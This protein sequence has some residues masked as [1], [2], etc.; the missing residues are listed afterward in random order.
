MTAV[1]PPDQQQLSSA[2]IPSRDAV[3]ARRAGVKIVHL[4]TVHTALDTRIFHKECVSLRKA[5]FQVVV[6]GSHAADEMVEG[7]QIRA[8]PKLQGRLQRMTL[9]QWHAFRAAL[10]ERADIYQ[11]HDPELMPL[12]L[13]LR[14]LGKRVVYDVHEDLRQKMWEKLYLSTPVKAVL[15]WMVARFEDLCGLAFNGIV[16]VTPR[17]AE[18]FPR[19]KTVLVRNY[20]EYGEFELQS[21]PDYQ[22]RPNH[23][24]Y[25]GSITANRGAWRMIEAVHRLNPELQA[26]LV[27]AGP[28][29][30]LRL[31]EEL[32]ASPEWTSVNYLGFLS[33]TGIGDA[34][35]QSRIGLLVLDPTPCYI[36]SY[37]MKLFEYMSAGLPVI[38]S[39][40]PLWREIVAEAQCG[41][42][43][44]GM[45]VEAISDAIRYLLEHPEEAEEMGKRGREA[46]R[47]LYFWEREAETLVNL[48]E[49]ILPR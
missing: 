3:H 12:G 7:I 44:D 33:R 42:L 30:T 43:V 4:T 16:T 6:I 40:F 26:T 11:F 2:T 37:P 19:R 39:D 22:S 35:S 25:V 15:S 23:I 8:L 18:Y 41:L 36:D 1:I 9:T 31:E 21:S 32:K 14:M 34:L 20:P 49:R 47:K 13:L 48:Y 29:G 45:N 5:G 46:A 24:A 38:A 27:L 28:I 17:I 10:V